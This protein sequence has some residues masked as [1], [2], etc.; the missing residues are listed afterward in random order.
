ML[1]C[2]L[3]RCLPHM[4]PTWMHGNQLTKGWWV[5]EEGRKEG[6]GWVVCLHRLG[7]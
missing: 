5:E 3:K 4:G 1:G 6:E 2:V 7:C